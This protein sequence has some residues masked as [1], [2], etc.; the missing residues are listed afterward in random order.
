LSTIL[1]TLQKSVKT[2]KCDEDYFNTC[3]P[4]NSDSY[5][6]NNRATLKNL[7][8]WLEN[9][10]TSRK[11]LFE[12]IKSIEDEELKEQQLLEVFNMFLK[13]LQTDHHACPQ[14]RGSYIKERI[15]TFSQPYCNV[16]S[17][18][19]GYSDG[20]MKPINAIKGRV[21][22]LRKYFEYYGFP[23]VSTSIFYTKIEIPKRREEEPEPLTNAMWLELYEATKDSQRKLYLRLEKTSGMRPREAMQLTEKHF[24][25][26]SSNGEKMEI[27]EKWS[28]LKN[29]P[30]FRK[31]R[32]LLH[33]TM[34]KTGK[35]RHTWVS[36]QIVDKMLKLLDE[37]DGELLFTKNPNPRK[38]VANMST[39]FNEMRTKL[40]EKNP[41]WLER[42]ENGE[43]K[44]LIYSLR[45]MFISDCGGAD[46]SGNAGHYW[47]G[48][49][50]YMQMYERKL[51]EIKKSLDL[52]N[53][54][55]EFLRDDRTTIPD[56]IEAEVSELRR[57]NMQLQEEKE[58]REIQH[59]N[60]IQRIHDEAG[61]QRL[62]DLANIQIQIAESQ[63]SKSK[64]KSKK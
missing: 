8:C 36:D 25:A 3:F 53:K 51:G 43:R 14:C 16:C 37:K 31:L 5:I 32:I 12:K 42:F 13:Y 52:Y 33:T 27:P 59:V 61:K 46:R 45:A 6:S 26:I 15:I 41:K 38:S 63:I 1:A 10:G 19:H 44:F 2:E 23:Q 17:S 11:E 62:E 20:T 50:K 22:H 55:E 24:Q 35:A 54:A 47:A 34:T 48:H 21:S 7:H 29:N 57:D 60:E 49:E 56:G 4:K 39:W 64:K 18:S 9:D 58:L 30:K 28:E 40:G